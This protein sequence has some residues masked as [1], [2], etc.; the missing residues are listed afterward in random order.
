MIPFV[1]GTRRSP[2][3]LFQAELVKS[4]MESA[5]ADVSVSIKTIVTTADVMPEARIAAMGGKGVFVKEIEEALLSGEIDAAAHS[6]KDVPAAL[7]EGL[8]LSRFLPRIDPRDALLSRG[9]CSVDQLPYGARVGTSSPRRAAWALHRRPDLR[10]EP[11]RGNVDTRL[12]KLEQGE[13]DATFLA[14]AGLR[15]LGLWDTYRPYIRPIDAHDC[16]PAVGQGIIALETRVGDVRAHALTDAIGCADSEAQARCERAFLAQFGEG[17]CTQP[18]GAIS[19]FSR[20]KVTL[21]A[22]AA[23]LDGS[24]VVRRTGYAPAEQAE[25]MAAEIGEALLRSMPY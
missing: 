20:G 7:P 13:V 1:I 8:H 12:R 21:H 24:F 14:A 3:A 19:E 6:L 23:S 9:G 15:R 2:L 10:I 5:R 25:K 4:L 11:F 18:I 22:F 16:V 17:S